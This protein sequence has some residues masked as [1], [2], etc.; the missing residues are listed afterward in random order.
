MLSEGEGRSLLVT[1]VAS[2]L[3]V[4]QCGHE[5]VQMQPLPLQFGAQI[6]FV[7]GRRRPDQFANEIFD[8]NATAL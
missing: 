7:F 4:D 6:V 3:F 5:L 1:D 8:I 2:S